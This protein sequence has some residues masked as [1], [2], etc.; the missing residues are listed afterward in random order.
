MHPKYKHK[1]SDCATA[2]GQVRF[3][4]PLKQLLAL[5]S[6]TLYKKIEKLLRIPD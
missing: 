5:K 1:Y 3:I 6:S 4:R 2:A